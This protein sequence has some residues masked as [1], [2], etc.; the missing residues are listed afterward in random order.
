M[1]QH[2]RPNDFPLAGWKTYAEYV[3]DVHRLCRWPIYHMENNNGRWD[4]VL[5]N[6]P[7]PCEEARGSE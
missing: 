6:T 4:F 2:P 3:A 5:C 7:K 1:C